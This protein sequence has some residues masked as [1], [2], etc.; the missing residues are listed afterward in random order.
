M[1]GEL[2]AL[3]S[4]S[5]HEDEQVAGEGVL[6]SSC[7]MANKASMGFHT[8]IGVAPMKVRTHRGT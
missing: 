3:V 7:T 8:S 5:R 4:P 6:S 2:F 1:L